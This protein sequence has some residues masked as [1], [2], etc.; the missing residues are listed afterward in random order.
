MSRGS[1]LRTFKA[2]AWSFMGIRKGSEYK[3]DMVKIN[4]I[5]VLVVGV[6]SA[7]IFVLGLMALVSWVVAK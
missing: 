1:F 6:I 3:E 7:L 4:P 2:V 5:H